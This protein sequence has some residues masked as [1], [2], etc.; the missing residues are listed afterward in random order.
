[1]KGGLQPNH[2][3]AKVRPS[4]WSAT[5][6]ALLLALTGVSCTTVKVKERP[7]HLTRQG[8][9]S[10]NLLLKAVESP[11]ETL[12]VFAH[13]SA[14][15]LRQAGKLESKGQPYDAA[16]CFLKAAV[17]ARDLLASH[18]EI[19]GSEAE[20]A[21]L[22]VHNR[23]LAR[24]AEIWSTDP[25]RAL[26]APHHFTCEGETFEIALAGDSD[27]AADYFDRAVAA[28]SLKGKGVVRKTRAGYGAALV[29]VREQR[30]ERAEEM[31]FHPGRGL[32]LPV[33]LV[34]G[35][36]RVVKSDAG[37]ITRVSFSLLD[38]LQQQT[39][40]IGGRRLPLA[41]DFS[42]PMEMMLDGRSEALWALDG[43]FDADKRASESGIYLIEPYDPGRIPVI[44]THGL[45][46]VPIIWRD[47]VPELISEPDIS[48]RYQFMVFTYPSSF[49]IIESA[50]LFRSKLADLRAHHDPQGRDPLSRD[51]VAMG[52][53]MGGVLTHLLVADVGDHL[54]DE[55]SDVHIDEL[56]LTDPQKARARELA[57]FRPDPAVNRAVFISA[58]HRGAKMAEASFSSIISRLAS[59]PAEILAD[60][61]ALLTPDT[62]P[63]LKI[64]VSK[65]I[66]SVQSLR[67]DSPISQTLGKAPYRAGVTYHSIIGDRGKGDTPESSDGVVEY[68]SS[69]QPGAASELIVPTDHS[70]YKHPLAVAEIKR[71]LREH[72]DIR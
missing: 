26:P 28:E 61:E 31:R 42:A 68:W 37:T 10:A 40:E 65:K 21:L 9:A 66:T 69:H 7:E 36:K 30:P 20:R 32:K 1:M 2:P 64:D 27:F 19:P 34:I 6:A 25:R 56:P 71:I 38:S 39:I 43:F 50:H 60:T 11:V 29:G 67:P 13:G 12:R 24:F 47:L 57:L 53:S 35:E 70:S 4:F 59:L 41:A 15:L 52:H 63:H 46:S 58:P 33:T 22:D 62:V 23:A 51:V 17:D 18:A 49:S 44:L 14:D 45:I 5:G 3:A 8:I 55:I 54:W 16:A 48:R 72:A